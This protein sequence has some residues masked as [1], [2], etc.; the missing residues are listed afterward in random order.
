MR[1]ENTHS[2]EWS[3]DR[4]DKLFEFLNLLSVIHLAGKF[5][6]YDSYCS[7]YEDVF[8]WILEVF[9]DLNNM[10]DLADD[11]ENIKIQVRP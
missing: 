2:I 1:H 5:Y 7:M 4:H 9:D 10:E 6:N 8:E 3:I 11:L